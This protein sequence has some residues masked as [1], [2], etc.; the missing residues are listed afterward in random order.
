MPL[1]EKKKNEKRE[2]ENAVFVPAHGVCT[3]AG[4]SDQL[5]FPQLVSIQPILNTFPLAKLA[6]R[7][8]KCAFLLKVTNSYTTI[9]QNFQR[10]L[11]F[12]MKCVFY[13]KSFFVCVLLDEVS[14]WMQQ[15]ER[16][17]ALGVFL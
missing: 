6:S 16:L 9:H 13:L 17:S 3:A 2:K 5:P 15:M 8:Q 10:Y 4:E 14:R 12:D 7:K 11:S 1:K